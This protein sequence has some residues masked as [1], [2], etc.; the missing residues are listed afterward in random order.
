[1]DFCHIE[2]S[3]PDQIWNNFSITEEKYTKAS[4]S[5]TVSLEVFYKRNVM[6]SHIIISK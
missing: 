3:A 2:K 4:Y 5:L 1:M 6:T